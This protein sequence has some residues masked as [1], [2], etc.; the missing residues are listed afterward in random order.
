MTP[1][2]IAKQKQID[3]EGAAKTERE[4]MRHGMDS[5]GPNWTAAAS[6]ALL[7]VIAL[8]F[9]ALALPRAFKVAIKIFEVL[10]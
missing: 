1:E 6:M 2:D 5:N 7:I 3:P 9:S 10:L 8:T 4:H